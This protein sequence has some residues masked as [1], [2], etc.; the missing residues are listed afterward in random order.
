[1]A[2]KNKIII[3]LIAQI[4]V[5][6]LVYVV[7]P[8]INSR[9]DISGDIFNGGWLFDDLLAGRA[10]LIIVPLLTIIVMMTLVN[11]FRYWLIGIPTYF[12]LKLIY[13]P[14]ELYDNLFGLDKLNVDFA[15]GVTFFL[16]IFSW[17]FVRFIMLVNKKKMRN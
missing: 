7:D 15:F 14:D 9:L 4:I 2:R 8:F 11:E 6:F 3:V 1:M 16:Q 10:Y 12:I 17:F 13:Y 5:Y